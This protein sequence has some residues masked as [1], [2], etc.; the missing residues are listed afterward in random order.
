MGRAAL[1]LGRL[2]IKETVPAGRKPFVTASREAS[3]CSSMWRRTAATGQGSSSLLWHMDGWH[4]D[5]WHALELAA[6]M[7]MVAVA[8][9]VA[10]GRQLWVKSRPGTMARLLVAYGTIVTIADSW[11]L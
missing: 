1:G 10:G 2:G 9:E 7:S 5:G 11:L 4:M 6:L 3:H 8:K